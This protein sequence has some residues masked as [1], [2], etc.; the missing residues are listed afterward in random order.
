MYELFSVCIKVLIFES[1]GVFVSTCYL[2]VVLKPYNGCV[3]VVWFSDILC[4]GTLCALCEC[5]WCCIVVSL[6]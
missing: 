2:I 3:N 5:I 1:I 6:Y 4:V